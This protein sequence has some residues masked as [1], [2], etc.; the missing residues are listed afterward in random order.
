MAHVIRD[1][2]D[3]AAYLAQTEPKQK[4]KAAKQWVAELIQDLSRKVN[5]RRVVLPWQKAGAL[6]S[7]LPGEVTC[8]AGVNGHGKSLM[9]GQVVL[10]LMAQDERVCVASFEMKPKKTLERMTRQ[11]SGQNPSGEWLRSPEV[12]ASFTD[13]YEQFGAFSDGRLWL[14]DQQG[15][16]K[17]PTI[18]G[19]IRYCAQELRIQHIVIDNMAKCIKGADDYNA[20]ADFVDELCAAARDWNIHI[21]LVHH[22]KK[23]GSE[24]D[25]PDKMDVKGAGEIVDQVDNLL[26]VWRN[27]RKEKDAAAGKKVAADECD[28]FLICDKQRNGDWEGRIAL[29][30]DAESQQFVG[31]PGAQSLNF[32][33]FPHEH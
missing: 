31:S 26:I 30:Y 16:V 19:V 28:A 10:S 7:F 12:I 22:I 25:V 11:W 23:L 33:T 8:W 9:T 24:T 29:W 4:V 1:D 32:M 3:F 15:T 21:H 2:I 14:Y 6:F 5:Q 27:K 18:L 17:T 13:L 20:Q